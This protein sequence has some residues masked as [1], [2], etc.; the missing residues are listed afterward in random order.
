MQLHTPIHKGFAGFKFGIY[1]DAGAHTCLGF[2]GSRGYENEDAA[3]FANWGVDFLKYDNCFAPP[4][5]WIVDRYVAMRDALNQTGRPI[6]FSMCNWGVGDPWSGWGQQ[7]Q[8][9]MILFI[10][11]S[12]YASEHMKDMQA[13]GAMPLDPC[14]APT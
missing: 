12:A 5:D 2:P 4:N 3:T 8:M 6:V 11:R 7:V 13:I 9:C 1:S 10:T 14:L